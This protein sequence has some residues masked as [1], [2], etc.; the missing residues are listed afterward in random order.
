MFK[1]HFRELIDNMKIKPK[2]CTDYNPQA[3]GVIERVHQVLGNSL[4]TLE[5]SGREMTEESSLEPVFTRI[6]Y[7]IRCAY[8]T[9]LQATPGQLVFGRDMILP[10][11]FRADWTQIQLRKQSE[12]NRSNRK[13][14]S[15]R[16]AHDYSVGDQVL[17]AKPGKLNKLQAP[18]AG[19]YNVVQ[20]N[21]NG[22]VNIQK[23]VVTQ[24][25]NIRR[26]QPYFS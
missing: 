9:T 14:N 10:I 19:P 12:I 20:V 11:Q 23:G 1:L 7:A 24:T 25:V 26:L 16:I 17:L 18:R 3:N 21:D 22:T 2:P 15:K 13:E 8:H 6:A 5:V 4:R